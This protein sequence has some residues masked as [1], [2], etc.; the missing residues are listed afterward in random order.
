MYSFVN[1]YFYFI[2]LFF[3]RSTGAIL[4]V[5]PSGIVSTFASS[6]LLGSGQGKGLTVDNVGNVYVCQSALNQVWMI[7][8]NGQTVTVFATGL[9]SAWTGTFNSVTGALYLTNFGSTAVSQVLNAESITCNAA[10][11]TNGIGAT[12][13]L[14]SCPITCNSGYTIVNTAQTCT[15]GGILTGTPQ[16]CLIAW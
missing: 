1:F 14:G 6:T 7:T 9:N 11:P 15:G 8:A 2:I 4:S 16:L 12:C 5:N 10:A 13:G 3:V